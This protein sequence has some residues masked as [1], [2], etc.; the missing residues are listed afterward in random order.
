[1]ILL[2]NFL[3]AK[4]LY[5]SQWQE[6]A[7]WHPFIKALNKLEWRTFTRSQ[8]LSLFSSSFKEQKKSFIS[9]FPDR[10]ISRIFGSIFN[11]KKHNSSSFFY[12]GKL[13]R[14]ASGDHVTKLFASVMFWQN[15]IVRFSL[16]S[17]SLSS[18]NI[19]S[20]ERAFTLEGSRF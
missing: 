3:H 14:A 15:R 11:E 12:F 19:S 17:L 7:Y 1:M 4:L 13:L 8:H 2:N 18:S 9:F 5:Q 16:T 10:R 6:M 20:F